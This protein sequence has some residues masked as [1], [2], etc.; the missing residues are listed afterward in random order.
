ITA[1]PFV[2]RDPATIPPRQLLYG[3]HYVRKHVSAT[4]APGGLGKSSLTQVESLEMASGCSLLRGETSKRLKVWYFNL[5]DPL[6]E[7]ERR[8]AAIMLYYKIEPDAIEGRLFINSRRDEPLI[9]GEKAKDST[10]IHK[11]VV[12]AIISEIRE[13]EIDVLIID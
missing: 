13:R 7:V 4:I 3:K 8:I 9:I 10:V 11:P 6:D 12:D 5:E 2:W 1:R